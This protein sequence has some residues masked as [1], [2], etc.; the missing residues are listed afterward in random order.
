[1]V[2]SYSLKIRCEYNLFETSMSSKNRTRKKAH[3]YAYILPPTDNAG[4]SINYNLDFS[5]VS[6]LLNC[7]HSIKSATNKPKIHR[8]IDT[9]YKIHINFKNKLILA[10]SW[11][12]KLTSLPQNLLYYL[13]FSFFCKQLNEA[14]DPSPA[15]LFK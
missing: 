14:G 6:Y 13:I 9:H 1:M 11:F 8:Q 3:F 4:Y 10:I 15:S 2:S 5:K 12:H 7:Q